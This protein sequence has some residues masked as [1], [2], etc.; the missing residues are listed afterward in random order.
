[1]EIVWF[2]NYRYRPEINM[3]TWSS[4]LLVPE[5]YT[6]QEYRNLCLKR[7]GEDSSLIDEDVKN[8]IG[9]QL[10]YYPINFNPKQ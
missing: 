6:Y 8:Y 2:Q 10:P 9:R 3:G 4:S 5:R 1:M 7:L